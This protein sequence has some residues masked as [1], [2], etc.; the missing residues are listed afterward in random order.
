MARNVSE[1][2]VSVHLST[3]HKIPEDLNL[4]HNTVRTSHL[5]IN[6][7]E[8]STTY[9]QNSQPSKYLI[10]APLE[11]L[12]PDG[13][14]TVLC[15][16]ATLVTVGQCTW[17]NIAEDLN[18]H[19]HH[20]GSFGSHEI[21]VLRFILTILPQLQLVLSKCKLHKTFSSKT[22]CASFVSPVQT[23]C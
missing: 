21:T 15:Y 7:H 3:R 22:K 5:V 16:F 1:T 12:D 20:C 8:E 17:H 11:L 23:A 4:H 9:L 13:E 18:Y 14:G 6:I 19:F 10:F 2:L